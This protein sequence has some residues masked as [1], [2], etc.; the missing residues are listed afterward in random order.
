LLRFHPEFG[1]LVR[2]R[3]GLR[4]AKGIGRV[5][6]RQVQK[7][8]PF[9]RTFG[10]TRMLGPTFNVDPG[11]LVVDRRLGEPKVLGEGLPVCGTVGAGELGR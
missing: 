5:P 6:K 9:N 10:L 1:R 3:G 11:E 8:E 7:V 4:A 2:T